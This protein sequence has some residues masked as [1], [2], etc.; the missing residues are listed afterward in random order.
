MRLR[1]TPRGAAPAERSAPR[2]LLTIFDAD[3]LLQ[4]RTPIDARHAV[5]RATRRGVIVTPRSS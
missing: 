1:T 3:V 5:A 2:Q 4:T